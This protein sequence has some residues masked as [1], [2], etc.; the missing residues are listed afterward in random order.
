MQRAC[1][2]SSIEILVVDAHGLVR[3]C[4]SVLLEREPG[5]TVVGT[6]AT[7]VDAVDVAPRLRPH[8]IV[9]D[10]TLPLLNGL[11]A[12]RQI[13]AALPATQT[14]TLSASH[15]SEHVFSTLH[16]GAKRYVLKQSASTE[17]MKAIWVT[18]AG[19]R[20][21]SPEIDEVRI[22]ELLA[23][24]KFLGPVDSLS[25][26]G[27][28]ECDQ[29]RELRDCQQPGPSLKVLD[30][31][32]RESVTKATV[33]NSRQIPTRLRCILRPMHLALSQR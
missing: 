26:R 32:M 8:V 16:A 21:L 30:R 28:I 18:R 7:G 14:V 13:H 17:L 24:S 9:M 22:T 27:G 6:A 1:E 29:P 3:E 33:N 11:D 4:L 25:H 23:N 2:A 12:I 19:G 15:T 31:T 5:M 10:P 20:Y